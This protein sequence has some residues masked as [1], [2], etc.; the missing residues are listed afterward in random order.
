MLSTESMAMATQAP[1][2]PT[3]KLEKRTMANSNF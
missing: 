1:S 2:I 3:P